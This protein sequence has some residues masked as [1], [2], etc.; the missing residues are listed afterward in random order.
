MWHTWKRNEDVSRFIFTTVP[1]WLCLHCCGCSPQRIQQAPRDHSGCKCCCWLLHYLYG[2]SQPEDIWG[3]IV[4]QSSV[5][6]K[7]DSWR[8]TT[9]LSLP[10][11]NFKSGSLFFLTKLPIRRLT[12]LIPL[13]LHWVN[14][15]KLCAKNMF[16]WIPTCPKIQYITTK[17][18]TSVI[19]G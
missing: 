1:G 6:M 17:W 12:H 8:E 11:S 5:F 4:H 2:E 16:T 19:L 14:H 18:L 7:S 13:I 3:E 10:I 15:C 9:L